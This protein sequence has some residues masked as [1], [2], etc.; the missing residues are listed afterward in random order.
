MRA[1]S[2]PRCA[3][4]PLLSQGFLLITFTRFLQLTPAA[5]K[6]LVTLY[7]RLRSE[8]AQ[9]YGR[10]SYR[11]TVR[12]LESMVRLSEAIARA[13]CTEEVR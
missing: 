12:Q 8:D 3:T 7:G 10:S 4:S 1:P 6:Q 13:N 9:G 11:V 5:S 2:T